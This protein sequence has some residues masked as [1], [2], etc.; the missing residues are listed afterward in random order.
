MENVTWKWDHFVRSSREKA[1]IEAKGPGICP[2]SAHRR[3]DS[4]WFKK[5]RKGHFGENSAFLKSVS[6]RK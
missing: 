5:A 1:R 6:S 2:F 3:V 4:I